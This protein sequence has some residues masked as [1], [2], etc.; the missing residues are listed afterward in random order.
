M[1]EANDVSPMTEQ[2]WRLDMRVRADT[3]S[4]A[5]VREA[6]GTLAIPPDIL[7]DAKV[8]VSELVGN[9]VKHAGLSVDDHVHVTAE[10]S[11][12]RLRVTVH[13]RVRPSTPRPSPPRSG[14]VPERTPA[15]GCSSS[16]ASRVAGG[17]TKP[18]T[19][20]SWTALARLGA[21]TWGPPP[22]RSGPACPHA[23][24]PRCSGPCRA[25]CPR[26]RA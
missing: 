19:G 26:C 14:L 9:S 2:R 8:L 24:G 5:E 12:E 1:V 7:E 21:R 6:L 20:S 18:A 22:R 17:P 25:R 3:G 10:W 4:L 16:I 13:D 15:G 11:G 23:F